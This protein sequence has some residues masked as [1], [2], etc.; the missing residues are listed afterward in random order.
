MLFQEP[1]AVGDI[2]VNNIFDTVSN[3][4]GELETETKLVLKLKNTE[5]WPQNPNDRCLNSVTHF[6]MSNY[7]RIIG[8]ILSKTGSI[9][10][11][12]SELFSVSSLCF[13]VRHFIWQNSRHQLTLQNLMKDNYLSWTN[14]VSDAYHQWRRLV[15]GSS[16]VTGAAQFP[17]VKHDFVFPRVFGV[18]PH[19]GM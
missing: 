6:Y 9:H 5:T 16:E 13:L 3:F 12:R 8:L 2:L 17:K 4:S 10:E 14:I 15:D 7:F 11:K 18:I 1:N 19:L